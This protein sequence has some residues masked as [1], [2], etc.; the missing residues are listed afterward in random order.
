[1]ARPGKQGAPFVSDSCGCFASEM[2]VAARSGIQWRSRE[3]ESEFSWLDYWVVDVADIP[4]RA[5]WGESFGQDP[6]AAQRELSSL[7]EHPVEL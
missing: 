6:S 5:S 1:M 2:V 3:L 4:W 7:R